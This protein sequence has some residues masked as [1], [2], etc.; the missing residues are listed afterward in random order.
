MKENPEKSQGD[1]PNLSMESYRKDFKQ[2]VAEELF[3]YLY[4]KDNHND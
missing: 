4:G 1:E 3:N 2:L